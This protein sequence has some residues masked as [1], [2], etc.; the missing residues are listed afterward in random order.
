MMTAAGIDFPHR[1]LFL[2]LFDQGIFLVGG[3]YVTCCSTGPARPSKD[4]DLVVVGSDYEK[5][6]ATLGRYGHTNT[7]GKSFAVVKFTIDQMTY[8]VAV[9][10][11]ERV[12]DPEA[13]DHRNFVIESG[14]HVSLEEDL[15]RR[16]FTCNPWPAVS[17][18]VS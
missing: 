9:P 13:R 16:D 8:D 7:V 1:P 2:R 3:R 10:R 12:K 14:E 18:T 4:L 17:A 6:A 5:L 15:G 11:K